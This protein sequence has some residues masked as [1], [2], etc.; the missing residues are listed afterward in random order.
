[1]KRDARKFKNQQLL[2]LV[3]EV[4]YESE[5]NGDDKIS[6]EQFTNYFLKENGF[7]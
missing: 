5:S 1:M 3:N 6:L 4:F 2:P 7:E